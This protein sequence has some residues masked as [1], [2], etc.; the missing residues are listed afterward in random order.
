MTAKLI[1]I[2]FS[3]TLLSKAQ[4]A[5]SLIQI[6][7]AIGDTL[8]LFERNYF[9]LYAEIKDFDYAVIYLSEKDSLISKFYSSNNDTVN[10]QI[11]I[12][13]LSSLDSLRKIIQSI[14]I[15][16]SELFKYQPD[17]LLSTKDG[18]VIEA[19]IEMFDENYLYIIASYITAEHTGMNRYRIPVTHVTELTLE[20]SSNVLAGMC[21]GGTI[22][23]VI[24]A[25]VSSNIKSNAKKGPDSFDNCAADMDASFNAAAAFVAIALGAFL[26]GAFIGAG[27]SSDDQVIY[28]DSNMDVLKLRGHCAYILNKDI[29]KDRKYHDIY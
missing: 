3:F 18:N 24:G 6:Y 10:M 16:N 11:R 1:I 25:L 28:F 12:Q 2:F 21:I 26:V 9:G 27:T 29:L 23:L 19:Q 7:P 4:N 17:I 13:D 20:G 22:G 5:D 15:I 14:D 8:S